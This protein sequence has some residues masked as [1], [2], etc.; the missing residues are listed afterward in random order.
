[1]LLGRIFGKVTTKDF[2][3]LAEGEVRKFEYVQVYHEVYEYVLCQIIELEKQE[4]MTTALCQII[5][6]KDKDGKVKKLRIPFEP[7]SEVLTADDDFISSIIQ[8]QDSDT[9]AY[10]GKLEG[11][12]ISVKL[13]LK[14]LLTK[15][16]AVLAKSGS[17]KSYAVGVLLEE[18]IDK[19]VPLLI[20]D[21]HG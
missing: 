5:G 6:F 1:M 21:T 8:L 7:G 14:K 12:D 15:H 20:I 17:G 9:G 13:D 2:K 11:R 3:F 10:L 16:V 19:K 4:N 18:I